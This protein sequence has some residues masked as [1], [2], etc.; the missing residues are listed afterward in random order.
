VFR[1]PNESTVAQ[2]I[3][4]TIERGLHPKVKAAHVR[5]KSVHGFL[6]LRESMQGWYIAVE[7]CLRPPNGPFVLD[8]QS[9][10]HLIASSHMEID[11]A[12]LLIFFKPINNNLLL[13]IM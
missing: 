8:S 13:L 10:P 5:M 11:N 2:V 7:P 4:S 9:K 6:S 1:S 3:I 12:K